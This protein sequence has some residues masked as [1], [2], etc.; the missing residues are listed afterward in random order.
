M[1][2]PPG[3]DATDDISVVAE[4]GRAGCSAQVQ[5]DGRYELHLPSGR[6]TLVA[7]ADE[8]VGVVPDVLA[9]AGDAHDVDIRLGAGAAIEGKLRTPSG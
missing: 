5:G 2:F 9:R 8:L 4:D 6:Y 1:L 7:S 3:T